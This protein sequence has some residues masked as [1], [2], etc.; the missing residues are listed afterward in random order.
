M[1]NLTLMTSQAIVRP[2]AQNSLLQMERKEFI[3]R[4]HKFLTE[5]THSS[6]YLYLLI[7]IEK[8]RCS[9]KVAGLGTHANFG[10]SQI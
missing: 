3:E 9:K 4:Y 10:A 8:S 1:D 5:L 6:R 2:L 7:E